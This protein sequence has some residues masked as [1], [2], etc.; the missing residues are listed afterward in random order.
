MAVNVT[1]EVLA[2]SSDKKKTKSNQFPECFTYETKKNGEKA[3]H[4][5]LILKSLV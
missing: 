1:W 5:F 2:I 3:L 4:F